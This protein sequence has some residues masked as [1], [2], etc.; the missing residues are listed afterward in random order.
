MCMWGEGV[1]QNDFSG[2]RVSQGGSVF[3]LALKL[4]NTIQRDDLTSTS[5]SR[6]CFL[7]VLSGTL[8]ADGADK[9]PK[10]ELWEA[11]LLHPS[12]PVAWPPSCRLRGQSHDTR[13]PA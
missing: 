2:P 4:L 1:D 11:P 6:L 8:K 5:V 12:K 7:G 3:S 9:G 10:A 13:A